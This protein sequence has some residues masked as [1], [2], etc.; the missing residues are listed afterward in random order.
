MIPGLFIYD[1]DFAQYRFNADHPFNPRRLLATRDLAQSLDWLSPE[2]LVRPTRPPSKLLE[3]AHSP[4]YIDLVQRV[5]ETGRKTYGIERLGLGTDDNPV[6]VGMHEAASLAVGGTLKAAELVVNGQ[7]RRAINLA[8]GLHHAGQ[9]HASGFCIY[10]DIVVA[11]RWIRQQTGWRVL[12]VETDAHHGD[13]VQDAFYDD[14]NVFFLS[15]HESGQYLFPG[16]G[17]VDQ[18]GVGS[19]RGTTLNVP[20]APATDDASWIQAFRYT[21]LPVI[22]GFSPDIVVS[23]HGCD[24]H[25]WDPLADLCATTRFYDATSRLLAQWINQYTAGRWIATGG[26]GYQTLSVVPRVW[27]IV[28]AVMSEQSMSQDLAIPNDWLT[29]W[30]PESPSKLPTKLFDDGD[31]FHP[32]RDRHR[33]IAANQETLR[34]LARL[35]PTFNFPT[36]IDTID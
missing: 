30:Q 16:T 10:N 33:M 1:E 22:Q 15:L 8:G 32:I 27:S 2:L 11:I 17:Q 23:Q 34:R 9:G 29:R 35:F 12:Y 13:G 6:F 19:G 4:H 7:T 21:V 26:G 36:K 3:L 25:Y 24:G 14:P 18:I 28:W 5:S 31:Q 20:L